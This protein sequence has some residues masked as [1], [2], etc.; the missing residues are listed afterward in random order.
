[1]PVGSSTGRILGP[2]VEYVHKSPDD[3]AQA[4]YMLTPNVVHYAD[5]ADHD[6][7]RLLLRIDL[8]ASLE[9]VSKVVAVWSAIMS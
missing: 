9:H 2:K 7:T 1:M 4:V 6:R 5:C 3:Q 8:C